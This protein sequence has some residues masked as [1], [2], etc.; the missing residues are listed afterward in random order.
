MSYFSSITNINVERMILATMF[1]GA[2]A[3]VIFIKRRRKG[4]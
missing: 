3:L 4:S 2:V 1:M